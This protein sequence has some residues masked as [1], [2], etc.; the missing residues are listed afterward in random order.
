VFKTLRA[1][2]IA[3]YILIVFLCLFLAGSAAVLLISR[4]QEVVARRNMRL[5][6]VAWSAGCRPSWPSGRLSPR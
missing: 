4:Y 3:S 1:K 5:L 6:A 2:I